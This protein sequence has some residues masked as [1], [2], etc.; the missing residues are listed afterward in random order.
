VA[1]NG[2][3]AAVLGTLFLYPLIFFAGLWVPR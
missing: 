1:A 3:V 2:V